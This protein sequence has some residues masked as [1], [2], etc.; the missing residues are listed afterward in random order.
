MSILSQ[1]FKKYRDRQ[2]LVTFVAGMLVGATFMWMSTSAQRTIIPPYASSACVQ[3]KIKADE[4]GWHVIHVFYGNTSHIADNSAIPTEYFPMVHWFSQLR[5]DE[6]V[7]SLLRNK[8]NG[9]FI[10][11]AANDAVRISNTYA[12]ETNFGWTGLCVEPNPMYWA[13][14]SYR[15]CNVVGAVVGQ[16]TMGE[17]W[18]KFPNRAGPKG[19]IIGKEFDNHER[20]KF[21]EDR[22]RYTVTLLEIFQ[23]FHTPKV[24]DYLSLDVEGAED[25]VMNSFPFHSYRFNILTV[26]RPSKDLQSILKRNGYILLRQLKNWGETLWIHKSIEATVDTVAA[27]MID[28][29][30]YK[31]RETLPPSFESLI[32]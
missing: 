9:Y 8:R 27:D 21:D 26:E 32:N 31:Y 28:T 24:I 3:H 1:F 10:D 19:G 6:V 29:Q 2:I 22:P 20:S 23:R 16:E 15:A 4:R 30:N 7:F 25:F 18:F 13:S 12:L 14:L 17:F 5:Q 11:L